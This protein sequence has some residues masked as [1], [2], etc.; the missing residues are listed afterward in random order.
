M[1]E[2]STPRTSLL[3]VIL[4]LCFSAGMTYY[5]LGIFLPR[6]QERAETL[7]I[8]GGYSLGNDFYPVWLTSLEA[9]R[10]HRDP[11]ERDMTRQI[12][13]GLYGHAIDGRNPS[14]PPADYRAF[15]YPIFL[16]LLFW[17]LS[18]L[19]FRIAR[20]GFA[21]AL[22]VLTAFSIR[23]WVRVLRRRV[24][25]RL[26]AI[27]MLLT[28]SSYPVLEGLFAGQ[29]G[30]FVGFLLAAS[31]ASLVEGTPFVA[32]SL[33]AFTMMKPQ[34]VAL[35]AIYLLLWSLARWRERR[36]FTYGFLVWSALL[37][38]LSLL[39]W[40]RWISKWMAVLSGYRDY[41]VPPL[42]GYLLG[43][44]LGPQLGP[45]LIVALLG[46]ALM[47]AWRM[48]NVAA[49]S[50]A[51]MLTVSLLLAVTSITLLPGHAVYDHVVLLPGILLISFTWRDITASSRPFRMV[52]AVGAL[53]LFWQWLVAIPLLALRP[54][55]S[56]ARFSSDAL[57]LL[58]FHAAASIPFAVAAVLG[59]MMWKVLREETALEGEER[60]PELV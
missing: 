12:Q 3:A 21:V 32:G 46:A 31:C 51:F 39:V 54:F 27:L 58:P 60:S 18:L 11:Y 41:S 49:A 59:L 37:M 28:L 44:K 16:D 13:V 33:F 5:H 53:V 47:L 17:P 34:M 29:A 10:Y 1:V 2:P 14:G 22:A 57:I 30:L 26:L 6:A 42:I 23:F 4:V 56:R 9:L 55:L 8:G 24:S 36:V 45:F 25:P 43:P 19:P 52:L 20:I 38:G 35:V 48:R 50:P 7:G 40:P 15:A